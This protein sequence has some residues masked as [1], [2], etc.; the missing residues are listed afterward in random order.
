MFLN[1]RRLYRKSWGPREDGIQESGCHRR[2]V[3]S[4][5]NGERGSTLTGKGIERVSQ[6]E[7]GEGYNVQLV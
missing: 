6:R 4:G 2:Q 3:L 5:F 7:R 1:G